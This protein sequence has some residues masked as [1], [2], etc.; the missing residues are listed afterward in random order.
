MGFY[1]KS[2]IF[3][4]SFIQANSELIAK[5][6]PKLWSYL[7][8]LS[9]SILSL[10]RITEI[11]TMFWKYLL[12]GPDY[13]NTSWQL[14]HVVFD[15]Q[16]RSWEEIYKENVASVEPG[17]YAQHKQALRNLQER[18]DLA[19]LFGARSLAFIE[20]K[21]VYI[22]SAKCKDKF[23]ALAEA[24]FDYQGPLL[25][26]RTLRTIDH[27]DSL[28]YGM[29]IAL[30]NYDP[31]NARIDCL[32]ISSEEINLYE[33]Y[34]KS[35]RYL[36]AIKD[37]VVAAI[38]RSQQEHILPGLGISNS[39]VMIGRAYTL[40]Q[41]NEK[42]IP[43]KAWEKSLNDYLSIVDQ[44]IADIKVMINSLNDPLI[45]EEAELRDIELLKTLE[46][47]K[48]YY[49]YVLK[50]GMSS[51]F[52]KNQNISILQLLL[53]ESKNM[54]AKIIET[55]NTLLVSGADPLRRR[56]LEQ[57]LSAMEI[58]KNLFNDVLF[59]F[60][61]FELDIPQESIVISKNLS[62]SMMKELAAKKK[63]QGVLTAVGGLGSHV[64]IFARN[65]NIPALVGIPGIEQMIN[66]NTTLIIDMLQNK[67]IL[68]PTNTTLKEYE[69][70]RKKIDR[71]N[72]LLAEDKLLPYEDK[73]GEPFTLSSSLDNLEQ[74][75]T[76]NNSGSAAIGLVRTE[77]LFYDR[78]TP[79]ETAEHYM[80]YS[81]IV[82]SNPE[83]K[84]RTFDFGGD[85]NEISFINRET[86]INYNNNLFARQKLGR[87]LLGV[88]FFAFWEAVRDNGLLHI[89]FPALESFADFI[90]YRKYYEQQKNEFVK[91]KNNGNDV[92]SEIEIG[93][94][95]ETKTI[96]KRWRFFPDNRIFKA[97][98]FL[99]IGSADLACSLLEI[100]AREKEYTIY[101]SLHPKVLKKIRS[102]KQKAA[103]QQ[104]AVSVCGNIGGDLLGAFV[105]YQLG[106]RELTISSFDIPKVAALFRE[107]DE[108]DQ[109]LVRRI[110][111]AADHRE[112]IALAT[113]YIQRKPQ[114]K[115]LF[116]K[117]MYT[118]P[119]V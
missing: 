113:G 58:S 49:E 1:Q 63:L 68:N 2:L 3:N 27:P 59:R 61:E 112:V 5:Q 83:A 11:E 64:L 71:L 99:S 78:V 46:F 105:F 96:D 28:R 103:K 67:L 21:I 47:E 111:H 60:C 75:K 7:E 4:E 51:T 22:H 40:H 16:T 106:I 50:L 35:R 38:K 73:L 10:K 116:D 117:L 65:S 86:R 82:Q 87:E 36:V 17:K 94:M 81:T 76:I 115:K 26:H 101:H 8:Q 6:G 107:L 20:K 23:K 52:K 29:V 14:E 108:I 98:D 84:I 104:K 95:L 114:L 109:Q 69:A 102:F 92:F 85:K 42:H 15:T 89:Y 25:S 119:E 30:N 31:R 9:A 57:N 77:N 41:F 70:L 97:A 12:L 34:E 80:F 118:F 88:M 100:T 19:Q 90:Y 13:K 43:T 37:L 24:G 32:F 33:N 93:A 54:N 44:K 39:Q 110:L 72:E 53:N 79:P 66:D 48:D 62:N 91:L 56:Q 74:L 45:T 55:E 18:S